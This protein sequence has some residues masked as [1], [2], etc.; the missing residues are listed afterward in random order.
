M[1][2]GGSNAS[3][4]VTC[5]ATTV[6]VQS[7]PN[8]KSTFG[9]RVNVVLGLALVVN[10]CEPEEAQEMVKLEPLA[11]TDSL[12][13]TVMF[14]FAAA[15]GA[16]FV[17]VVD[18]V[19]VTLGGLSVVNDQTKFASMLSGGS[20][21]S[22]SLTC[23]ASTVAVHSSLLP[24]SVFGSTVHVV[25]PPLTVTVCA[26]VLTQLMVTELLVMVTGSLNVTERFVFVAT[27]VEPFVGV[28]AVTL[29]AA[30]T[31]NVNA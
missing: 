17:G 31:V 1:L 28:T 15:C 13:L 22:L 25:G 2:S 11:F 8:V 9:L 4:S 14:V 10:V 6:T 26:P 18:V 12:K 21:A 24:K 19:A 30:S 5:A 7:S 20:F 29:G 16:P 27:F 3:V 23:A